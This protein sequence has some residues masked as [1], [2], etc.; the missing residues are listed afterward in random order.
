LI[1]LES[2]I[3]LPCKQLSVVAESA[4][5]GAASQ[6]NMIIGRSQAPIYTNFS[7]PVIDITCEMLKV[8]VNEAGIFMLQND[9]N[10][11]V[12]ISSSAGDEIDVGEMLPRGGTFPMYGSGLL[13]VGKSKSAIYVCQALPPDPKGLY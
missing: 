6:P 13:G 9:G 2:A 11:V 7:G 3:N 4:F 5:Q 8:S 10:H 12:T 1:A